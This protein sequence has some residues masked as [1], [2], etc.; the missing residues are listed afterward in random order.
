MSTAADGGARIFPVLVFVLVPVVFHFVIVAT[1]DMPSAAGLSIALLFK[2]SFVTV[3]AVAHWAI[4]AGLLVTFGVTLRPNHEALIT[5]MARRLHGPLSEDIRVYTR[6]ATYAWCI[7]FA[8]QLTASVTLFLFA[9]LVVW[10]FFVNILDLPLVVA[11]FIAEYIFRI[12]HL[13]DPP[14]ESLR[15]ILGMI[16]DIRKSRAERASST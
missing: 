4:Y 3:S 11:M 8:A 5:F 6:R 12:H 10:S 9:P 16:N 2:V 1:S 14:R 7:F 15:A 13:Q